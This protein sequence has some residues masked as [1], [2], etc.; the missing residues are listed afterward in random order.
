MQNLPTQCVMTRRMASD[1]L[2]CDNVATVKSCNLTVV[3]GASMRNRM[4]LIIDL[5]ATCDEGDAWSPSDMEIIEIGAVL[6]RYDGTVQHEF[7]S[8]IRPTVCPQLSIFCTHLTGIKQTDVDNAGKFSDV[9]ANFANFVQSCYADH[10]DQVWGSWGQFDR[11]QLDLECERTSTVNPLATFTHIN[12]KRAFA[13]RRKI[14][15]VG[16]AKALQLAK[17]PLNGEHHR[18]LSDA[19]NI[20]SLVPWC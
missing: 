3:I 12:L 5:E 7:Q 6:A 11:K 18:A 9:M 19:R 10:M 20:A 2:A 8:F 4:I 13:N 16:M 14:K 17:L 15:E 1:L